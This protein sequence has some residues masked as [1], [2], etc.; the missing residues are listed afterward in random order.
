MG[1]Y[2]CTAC[3]SISLL[4][5]LSS[6]AFWLGFFIVF[7][8]NHGLIRTECWIENNDVVV[9]VCQDSW[10][11][12][13]PYTGKVEYCFNTTANVTF[14]EWFRRE[15]GKDPAK[16]KIYLLKYYHSGTRLNC[17]YYENNP[18]GGIYINPRSS[19][20]ILILA[21]VLSVNGVLLF[22]LSMACSKVRLIN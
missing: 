20:W 13:F 8:N 2:D 14:C 7:Y 3:F 6:L 12:E 11:V 21:S 19:T 1:K 10:I 16:I 4:L 5:L 15:C 22:I 18:W 17:F 9:K